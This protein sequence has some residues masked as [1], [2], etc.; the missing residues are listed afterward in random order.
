MAFCRLRRGVFHHIDYQVP[1]KTFQMDNAAATSQLVAMGRQIAE[2]NEN[3]DKVKKFFLDGQPIEPFRPLS[4]GL[5]SG[6]GLG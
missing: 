4:D 1:P 6:A 5:E 3:M 2:L